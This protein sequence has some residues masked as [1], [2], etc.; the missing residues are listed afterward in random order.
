MQPDQKFYK[1]AAGWAGFPGRLVE[2]FGQGVWSKVAVLQRVCQ[3]DAPPIRVVDDIWPR[4]MQFDMQ[5]RHFT[6][7]Q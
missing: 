3:L 5:L 1:Q 2:E 6:F 4:C 7:T